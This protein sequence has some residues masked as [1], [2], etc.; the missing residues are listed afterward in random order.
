MKFTH[1]NRYIALGA[2]F[3]LFGALAYYFSNIVAYVLIA[4]VLSM[5]G[6]PLMRL[7]QRN[8]KVWRFRAG[9]SIA[10]VLVL[11]IYFVVAILLIWLFVP[12][13]VKQAAQI[14]TVDLN[15]IA[16]T[17]EPPIQRANEWLTNHGLSEQIKSPSQQLRE[18]L[19][20][21]FDPSRIANIFSSFISITTGFLIDLFSIVFITFFFL[22]EQGLFVNLLTAIVPS[23]YEQQVRHAVDDASRLLTRYFGGILLQITIITTIVSIGLSIL[24]IKNAL[25]IGLFAALINVIPYV[26][27][28]IGAVFGVFVT[29]STHLDMDFY[30]QLIPLLVKVVS[31]F[32][33]MQLIDNFILQPFI[34]SNSVLAHP[35]EIFIV[36]LMGAKINGITGMILAIPAYTVIRL[37]ARVFLSEF[38]LVQKLTGGIESGSKKEDAPPPGK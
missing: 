24:G 19:L 18:V 9:K 8:L 28:I 3:L 27:P 17:L 22:K 26:G 12:L 25:L 1:L 36:I 21:S 20:G 5:I 29:I 32:I 33:F 15:S 16:N 37:V 23:Q 30:T 31:V 13:I 4:W 2:G 14:A 11:S 35:L 7:F 6:Q 38:K 10:A 34:F